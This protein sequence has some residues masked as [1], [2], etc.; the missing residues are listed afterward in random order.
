MRF[1][2]AFVPLTVSSA[3][4][5]GFIRVRSFERPDELFFFPTNV[6]V[7]YQDAGLSEGRARTAGMSPAGMNTMAYETAR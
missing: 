4:V 7:T 2:P 3:P 6:S 1:L 5:W